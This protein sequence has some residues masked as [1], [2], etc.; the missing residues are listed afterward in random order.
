MITVTVPVDAEVLEW[1]QAQGAD[2]EQ[3]M[4]AALRI[5]AEAHKA[6]QH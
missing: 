5:Y 2:Y 4:Q 1:F 6:T 3:R